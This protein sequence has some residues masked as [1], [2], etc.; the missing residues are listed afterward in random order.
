MSRFAKDLADLDREIGALNDAMAREASHSVARHSRR[1]NP[2]GTARSREWRCGEP[3]VGKGSDPGDQST[4]NRCVLE[5]GHE[6]WHNPTG[7]QLGGDHTFTVHYQTR[8]GRSASVTV[9]GE[10]KA[11]A[12]RTFMQTHRGT[13]RRVLSVT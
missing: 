6:G 12:L 1:A 7:A 4:W 11:A 13:F 2:F 9:K 10:H 5:K 8:A 3:V